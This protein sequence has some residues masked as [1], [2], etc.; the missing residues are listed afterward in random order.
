V[1]NFK[2]ATAIK[3]IRQ[4]CANFFL[5]FDSTENLIFPENYGTGCQTDGVEQVNN[6]LLLASK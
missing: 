2:V 3:T 5:N 6:L 1:S 4:C